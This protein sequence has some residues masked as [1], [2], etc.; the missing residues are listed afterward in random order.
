MLA[1]ALEMETGGC[2]DRDVG[3]EKDRSGTSLLL[4]AALVLKRWRL[5]VCSFEVGGI[6]GTAPA[7]T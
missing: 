4:R 5:G 7:S 3:C 1:V 2:G 6:T